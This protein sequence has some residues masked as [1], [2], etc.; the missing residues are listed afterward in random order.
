VGEVVG[1]GLADPQGVAAGV[2][3][4]ELVDAIGGVLP[5]PDP[6]QPAGWEP[7]ERGAQP[8]RKVS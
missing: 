6:G 7:A 3:D 1:G 4:Q 2:G 5:R 8:S